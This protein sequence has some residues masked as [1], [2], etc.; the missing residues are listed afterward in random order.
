LDYRIVYLNAQF[1]FAIL[2]IVLYALERI[3][4]KGQIP[5][6]LGALYFCFMLTLLLDSAWI[7]IDGRPELRTANIVL[8]LVYLSI[9]A[10]IGYIWFLYTLD[11]FPSKTRLRKY[12]YILGLPMIVNVLLAL[13][14]PATGLVFSIDD[15]G[16]YTR[17]PLHLISPAINYG[18]MLLGSYAALVARK[19]ALLTTDKRRLAVAAF[20]PLPILML[21]SLQ[22]LL[23]PGLPAFEGGVLISLLL[24]YATHQHLLVTRDQVTSLPNR[25]A[26]E[27]Y[28][29]DKIKSIQPGNHLYLIEGELDNFKEINETFGHSTGDRVIKIAADTLTNL[30]SRYGSLV[31]RY[32][33]IQFMIIIESPQPVDENKI[34]NNINKRLSEA[35]K[36]FFKNLSLSLGIAEFTSDSNFKSL[37]EEADL[38]LYKIRS[39]KD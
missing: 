32:G 19:E 2:F 13:S 26:F 20:F 31:F 21:V 5:K 9:M 35:G 38:N 28:L 18:Y 15:A 14:S 39:E 30:F 16:I 6:K 36:P 37:I 23:P 4:R 29:M 33:G 24:L 8:N 25:F 10:S 7:I 11:M 12:R 1:I 27:S 3:S 34:R 22:F 17:A